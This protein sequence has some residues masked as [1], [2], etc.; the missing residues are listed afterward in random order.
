MIFR[1]S[2]KVRNALGLKDSDL[3]VEPDQD[4][5]NFNDWYCNLITL[6]RH[7]CWLFTHEVSLFSFLAPG[8]RKTTPEKFGTIFRKELRASLEAEGFSAAESALLLWQGI[9][10]FSKARDRRIIG[11]MTD[12]ALACK[13]HVNAVGSL[14]QIGLPELSRRLNETP[15]SYLRM[16][17]ATEALK[18]AL[19]ERPQG[20]IFH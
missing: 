14:D 17:N 13:Y 11:S 2:L 18:T 5:R 10:A 7:P 12:H 1:C 9:D 8:S 19:Y 20:K 4:D 6:D 3:I 15:M 16:G